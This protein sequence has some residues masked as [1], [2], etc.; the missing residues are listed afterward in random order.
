MPETNR[1][2]DPIDRT[3]AKRMRTRFS[4]RET[5][6]APGDAAG[7]FE[8]C[9]AAGREFIERTSIADLLQSVFSDAANRRAVEDLVRGSL[10]V[11]FLFP[12]GELTCDQ[13]GEASV[14]AGFSAGFSTFSSTV[15][16]RELG[17]LSG[18]E[19]VPT[20]IFSAATNGACSRQGYVEAFIPAAGEALT[21]RWV[22]QEVAS[23]VGLTL[24]DHSASG[25]AHQAFLREGYVIAPFMHGEAIANP[26]AGVAVVYYDRPGAHGVSRIEVL[27]PMARVSG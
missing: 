20:L 27:Y 23:H 17:S 2:P 16:A 9:F 14:R 8:R 25:A 12:G 24:A 4:V 6:L 15:V 11:G 26:D 5:L 1:W 21:R 19:R 10:H 7:R 3:S 18:C 13:M 22:E